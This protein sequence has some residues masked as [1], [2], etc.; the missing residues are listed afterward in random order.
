MQIAG[1]WL[2]TSTSQMDSLVRLVQESFMA[3][4]ACG[5]G[6]GRERGPPAPHEAVVVLQGL[7][8]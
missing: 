2:K 4:P 1:G 5:F 3:V 6:L 7:C 8:K